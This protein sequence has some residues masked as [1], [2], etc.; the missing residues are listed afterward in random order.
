MSRDLLVVSDTGNHR[1]LL[2]HGGVP[3]RDHADADVVLG[4][5]DMVSEG[6]KRFF[7]PTGVAVLDGRLVVADAWH[8]R[9]L[10]WDGVPTTNDEEPAMVLG[11]PDGIDGVDEGCGPQRFYWPFG[12]ALVDGVFWVADTGNRRVLGWVD[13]VPTPGRGADVVLGQPDL[14]SRGENRDG[15]VA[16]DSV[17][18]PHAVASVGGTLFVADAGNHR[19]LGWH[20]PVGVDRPADIVIGQPGFDSAVEFPYRP[21][22]PQRFRF[23]YGVSSA[24]DGRLFVADTSNNRALVV[25][26]AS[27]TFAVTPVGERSIRCSASPISTRTAR[28]A[29]TG[30]WPTASV[31]RTGSIGAT[32]SSPSPTRATIVW[33]CGSNRDLPSGADGRRPERTAVRRRAALSGVVQGVG[34]RPFVH[35]LAGELRLAGVVGNDAGGVFVEVE[36]PAAE[37]D[38]FAERLV[39][40]LPPSPW[41]RQSWQEVPPSGDATFE[42]VASASSSGARTAIP[43]DVATCESCLAEVLDPAD[44]RYRY[45]FANCTDCGP[46]YT[47]VT[48]LPYDRPSTTMARFEMCA[49]CAAEYHDPGDRRHHAQPIACPGCG[50]HLTFER[51]GVAVRGTDAVIAALHDLIASGGVAAVKG[52]GGFHLACDATNVAA[53]AR[54]RERKGRADKPFAVMV[55]DLDAARALA[56]VDDHAAAALTS[57][58]A[59]IVLV[60]RRTDRPDA[61]ALGDV[62]APG[63]PLVGMMLPYS[64]L[65]HLLFRPVP[66]RATAPPRV[67]VLT[68][69]NRSNEPIC[70]DDD[71]ARERLADLVDAF[72]I[73][74]RPIHVPCDDSVVR[75][76]DG[77]VQPVRRSRGYAPV[78]VALPVDVRPVLAVGGELKNTFC[79]AAGRRAFVGPHVGDMENLETL[80]AFARGVDGFRRMYVIEPEVVAAD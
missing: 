65:H 79:L 64:P 50:P 61:V 7:L 18:W 72:V 46:R 51:D 67:L 39:T 56:H 21:Q 27:D 9:L 74:D 60:H 78:P 75:V 70:I 16:A 40:E 57:P 14:V 25:T 4:Q 63:N 48:D 11:Q 80:D 36:G 10:V 19:V 15:P 68:S 41:C 62:V 32:G 44:R 2:W 29:G 43:P 77:D 28:T 6:P 20:L 26:D 31:G 22:G 23:P 8:H 24:P 35:R 58:A 12:F 33:W 13:G 53:V 47:I 42:I 49:D 54:L 55:P 59:P 73:H 71:E 17:R 69:G 38:R 34:F 76:I 66:G 3:D 37:V 52:V 45:P 30:W 1:V 5:P